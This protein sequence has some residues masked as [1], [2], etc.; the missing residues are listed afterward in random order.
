MAAFNC[1]NSF[2][3]EIAG[4]WKLYKKKLEASPESFWGR[5]YERMHKFL[6]EAYKDIPEY[7]IDSK[8]TKFRRMLTPDGP[9]WKFGQNQFSVDFGTTAL[10][11]IYY[12]GTFYFANCGDSEVAIYSSVNHKRAELRIP[13][14]RHTFSNPK[15]QNRLSRDFPNTKFTKQ[16][17]IYNEKLNMCLGPSRALGHKYL[18]KDGVLPF[19]ELFKYIPGP[20]EHCRLV[21]ATDGVWDSMPKDFLCNHIFEK[22]IE[23]ICEILVTQEDQD[24]NASVIIIDYMPVVEDE[25]Y[26]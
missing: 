17:Y 11:V 9:Y 12:L 7:Y 25:D 4:H 3:N 13:F 21:L 5:M 22:P 24:D 6:V 15:E 10:M 19:P 18:Q 8:G 16:G 14:V 1:A 26:D 23:D 20:A 2:F